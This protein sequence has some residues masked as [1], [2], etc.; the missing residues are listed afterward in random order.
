MVRRTAQ[1]A[2]MTRTAIVA[3][4]RHLFATHG[5]AG[6]S[7]TAVVEA[8]GVTRGALYHHFEDKSALFREVFAD[9]TRELDATVTAAALGGRDV[10]DGFRRGCRALLDFAVRPDYHQIAV[11]DAPSVLGSE[12]W[13]AIDAG[14][15]LDTMTG[16][17]AALERAGLLRMPAGPALAVLVYGALTEAGIVLSRAAPGAPT[18]DELVDAVVGMVCAV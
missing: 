18:R 5:F 10:L 2:E 16:G 8:A 12:T 7:T 15:G 17:L 3:A 9:L 1:E 13:H 4:A 6:T 11:V 14:T